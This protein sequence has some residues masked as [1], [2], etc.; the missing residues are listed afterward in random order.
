[1]ANG[2]TA[3]GCS[4]V[5]IFMWCRFG[6][7]TAKHIMAHGT[8]VKPVPMLRGYF[9]LQHSDATIFENHLIPVIWLFM[10]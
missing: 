5:L 10:L 8:Y 9:C 4:P 6:L 3:V 2:S 7:V 1:M